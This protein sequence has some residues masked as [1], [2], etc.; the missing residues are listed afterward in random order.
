MVLILRVDTAGNVYVLAENYEV[1]RDTGEVAD[2]LLRRWPIL[3]KIRT[4]YPDPAEPDDTPTLKKKWRVER[5]PATGGELKTRLE[6]IRN[7]LKPPSPARTRST[8]PVSHQAGRAPD[9]PGVREPQPRDA[10]LPLSA[11]QR[12]EPKEPARRA[13]RRDDPRPEALGA[14]YRGYFGKIERPTGSTVR[15]S[16]ISRRPTRGRRRVAT[17]REG[18]AV[19]RRLDAVHHRPAA[20]GDPAGLGSGGRAR[21]HRELPPV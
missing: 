20:D 13:A 9:R 12:G 2:D 3:S 11:D 8:R 15:G 19:D 4:I 6:L 14:F 7:A 21:A 18:I 1:E 17:K 16:G 5:L 10:R